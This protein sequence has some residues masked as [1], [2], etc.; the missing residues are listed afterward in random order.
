MTALGGRVALVTGAGRGI[1]RAAALA[2]AAEGAQVVVASRT[3]A[4]GEETASLIREAG[5][6][7][8][9]ARTD[10]AR[11][12][13]ID[14]LFDLA[15]RTFGPVT[16]AFNN[17]GLQ[18]RRVALGAAAP[19]IY[20]R[21][22]DVNVRALLLC[23]QREIGDMIESGGGV[24]V[25]NAS[26]SGTR[27]PNPGLAL[28]CASK[29]AV[30]SLTRSAAMEY[31]PRNIRVNAVSPGRVRTAMMLASGIADMSEVARG[32]PLRRLGEPEEVAA[33]VVW[34]ASP[35]SA[36]VTGHVLAVDGGFLAQ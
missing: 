10:L 13:Q 24:I 11:P 30:I 6:A 19:E 9:F 22:F 36:F 21:V 14:A 3:A 16:V 25:N 26:V 29:A 33:A 5:G 4:E 20:A 28:Y 12:E 1:G 15:R 18:E 34:L 23:M 17:A 7:A 27:N 8:V 35:A 32:L 31:G 2:L